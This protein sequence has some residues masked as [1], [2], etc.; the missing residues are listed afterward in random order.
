MECKKGASR[1]YVERQGMDLQCALIFTV[2]LCSHT[3]IENHSQPIEIYSNFNLSY[4]Q[5]KKIS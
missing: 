2:C 4:K 5:W 1:V 3:T